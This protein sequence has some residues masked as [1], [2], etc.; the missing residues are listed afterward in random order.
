MPAAHILSGVAT[1]LLY[2]A[3]G[4]TARLIA[5]IAPEY[6]IRPLLAGRSQAA[7]AGVAHELGLESRAFPLDDVAT[8][9]LALDGVSV[10]LNCAGPFVHT[11]GPLAG[12]CIRN[13]VHY[14]D[15]TGEI[16]VFE[17]LHARAADARAAGVML[18]PGS[19]FD[20]V[21]SDCLAVHLK[22][23]LPT[24]TRLSL[25]VAGDGRISRGTAATMIE[26]AGRG[27]MIR[28]GG[29][30]TRVRLGAHTR[31]VDFGSGPKRVIT[32]PWGDVATAYYSTGIPD[33]EVY[34]VPPR[35]LRHVVPLARY[36]TWLLRAPALKHVL[37]KKVRSGPAGPSDA[38]LRTARSYVWGEVGDDAGN[39]A[40]ARCTGPNGYLL[41]AHAALV[42]TRRVLA[43]DFVPGFQTPALVYGPDLV[44]SVPGVERTNI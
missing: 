5:R 21:P 6:G 19:G 11:A 18:L 29:R 41:T 33:I 15:I 35:G 32:I 43:G 34:S 28:R 3:N 13:G 39:F 8:L 4:Y 2:G 31:E 17:Q 10:V 37:L 30:L 38:E 1:A 16:E 7:V 44:L 36:F 20:V 26:H 40:K 25:A 42:I 27:G 14:L 12:A 22:Q 23:R 9:D 24:A